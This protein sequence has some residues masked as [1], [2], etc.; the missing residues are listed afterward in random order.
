[1]DL[2]HKG[3]KRVAYFY[4]TEISKYTYARDHPMKPERIAM[5]HSLIN[6]YHIYRH[7]D[8]YMAREATKT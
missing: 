5:T 6:T 4:N 1:M 3:K 8:V 2:K 7:L